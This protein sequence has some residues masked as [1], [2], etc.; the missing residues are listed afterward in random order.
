MHI[1]LR[2]VYNAIIHGILYIEYII[3]LYIKYI[4]WTLNYAVFRLR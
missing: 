4:I 1:Q 3:F 2:Y